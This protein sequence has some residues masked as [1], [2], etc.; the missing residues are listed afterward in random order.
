MQASSSPLSSCP[1]FSIGLPAAE[2]REGKPEDAAEGALEASSKLTAAFQA[3][4]DLDEVAGKGKKSNGEKSMTLARGPPD[5][6]RHVLL[7]RQDKDFLVRDESPTGTFL[8]G[9]RFESH[10]LVVGD[11]FQ[12][13]GYSFE[14]TGI[15]LR[16]TR[17]RIGGKVEALGVGFRAGGRAILSEVT[18][19]I[20]QCSFSDTRWKRPGEVHFAQRAVRDKS[21]DDWL[22]AHRRTIDR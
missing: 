7:W 15:S 8:N 19:H 12:I 18:L 13:S 21:R 2:C 5:F 14:F 20:E 3:R 6:R 22:R 10:Q 17:P 16:R 4:Q 11:R 1:S 9:Q